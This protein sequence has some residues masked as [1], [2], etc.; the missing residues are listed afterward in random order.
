MKKLLAVLTVATFSF[1]Q[2]AAQEATFV[3]GTKVL[4]VGI[5]I[6]S[7]YYGG[8]YGSHSPALSGSF[9]VGI[10]DNVLEKG[11]IGIGGYVGY[12]SAKYADYWKTSNI[13]I[14]A[15]GSFHYPLVDKL[16]T[17]TGL[18]LGYNIFSTKYTDPTYTV[19][20]SASAVA[21]AWFAGAR[22]YFT[23]KFAGMAEVGYGI[24]YL[25]FGVAL[26][27]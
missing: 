21:L 22:Y 5:G 17:Y 7:N 8:L 20:G 9:E 18:L 1:V 10:K 14:G 12:S 26:K 15:R 13:L 16:D 11:S 27:F 25:T 24:A 3:K 6:G 2:L 4:N 23:D 19:G